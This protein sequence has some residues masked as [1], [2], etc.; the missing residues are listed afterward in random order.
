M[1]ASLLTLDVT[2]EIV[3]TAGSDG[4]HM[5]GSRHYLGEALD[6]RKWNIADVPA[7]V[8]AL[9]AQL[10]PKFSVLVEADHI[11]VQVKKGGRYP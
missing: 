7:F 4:K 6:I 11:H 3:I 10:G 8:K 9:Q 2:G 5:A 1:L